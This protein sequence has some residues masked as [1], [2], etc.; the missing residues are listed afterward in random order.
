MALEIQTEAIF[1]YE[2][3]ALPQWPNDQKQ[4]CCS[5]CNTPILV[6]EYC[7]RSRMGK[8]YCSNCLKEKIPTFERVIKKHLEALD[9]IRY[10]LKEQEENRKKRKK[11]G[12]SLKS[13]KG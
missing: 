6:G 12:K 11:P 4:P 2:F 3:G 5:K 10:R 7:L 9:I 13:L 8:P 1:A